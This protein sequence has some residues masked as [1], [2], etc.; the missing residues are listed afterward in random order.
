[1]ARLHQLVTGL[2]QIFAMVCAIHTI[3]TKYVRAFTY[4]LDTDKLF[5]QIKPKGR[6]ALD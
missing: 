5:D 3:V 6:N 2:G 4:D 1:M